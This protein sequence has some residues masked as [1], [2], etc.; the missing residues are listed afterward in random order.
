MAAVVD[1][2]PTTTETHTTP[3]VV[4]TGA[5]S[6]VDTRAGLDFHNRPNKT[7]SPR[8]AANGCSILLDVANAADQAPKPEVLGVPRR[9]KMARA[10]LVSA[11][12]VF[13]SCET[14]AASA[15]TPTDDANALPTPTGRQQKWHV[16][17][18]SSSDSLSALSIR[19]NVSVS[20]MIRWNKLPNSSKRKIPTKTLDILINPDCPDLILP[21]EMDQNITKLRHATGLSH[22]EALFYVNSG[23]TY[24]EVL[25]EAQQDL[26]WEESQY[27]KP[28][29]IM[30]TLEVD[31]TA[32]KNKF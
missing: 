32:A 20:D 7:D 13:A 24:E 21:G 4:D 18:V 19:Y 28:A 29:R 6:V 9:N 3:A 22:S 14:T 25:L 17:Q 31:S 23:N 26:K 16:H 11:V 12:P 10:M 5:D 1:E 27:K 15:G 2:A 8:L 30:E